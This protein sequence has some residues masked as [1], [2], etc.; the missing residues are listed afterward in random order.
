MIQRSV[1][2]TGERLCRVCV[3]ARAVGPGGADHPAGAAAAESRHEQGPPV[4]L[5]AVS[6]QAAG[7]GGS[8]KPSGRRL[9]AA[10]SANAPTGNQASAVRRP[11]VGCPG[12]LA[13]LPFVYLILR[14][15]ATV[16]A[17]FAYR[18]RSEIRTGIRRSASVRCL[19]ICRPK[20]AGR[21]R[22]SEVIAAGGSHSPRD[23]CLRPAGCESRRLRHSARL[24]R[25]AQGTALRTCCSWSPC[26]CRQS[27]MLCLG[28]S[29][30]VPLARTTT[31]VLG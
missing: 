26:R 18:P 20:Q 28:S 25:R 22:G 15:P 31:G 29:Q 16:V 13:T 2:T 5:G 14:G 6:D 30:P 10:L 11:L 4:P 24:G 21:P 17:P 3:A 8:E 12:S 9:T 27:L 7:Q 19:A 23:N 1:T